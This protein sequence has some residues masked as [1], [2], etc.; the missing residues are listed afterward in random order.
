MSAFIA[1]LNRGLAIELAKRSLFESARTMRALFFLEHHA[2]QAA[3]GRFSHLQQYI[4]LLGV[5]GKLRAFII[6]SRVVGDV[7]HLGAL[8]PSSEE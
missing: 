2:K 8:G 3:R 1:E 6:R 7:L 4:M 5:Q